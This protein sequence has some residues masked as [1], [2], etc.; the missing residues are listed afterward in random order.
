MRDFLLHQYV[1]HAQR[2][3]SG[4]VGINVDGILAWIGEN[5][6]LPV[7][8]IIGVG[9]VLASRRASLRDI[10]NQMVIVLIGLVLFFG[11]AYVF[12]VAKGAPA[13]IFQ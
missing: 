8:A 7:L 10:G 3:P 2:G 5:V 6:L 11:A 1:L 12:A 4:N 9:F 13:L